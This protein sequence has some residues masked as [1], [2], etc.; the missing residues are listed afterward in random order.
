M[1]NS[2]VWIFT[3]D[4]TNDTRITFTPDDVRSELE[5]EFDHEDPDVGRELMY[6]GGNYE[7]HELLSDLYYEIFDVNEK[8]DGGIELTDEE[9][10]VYGGYTLNALS[11]FENALQFLLESVVI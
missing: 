10:L 3:H 11:A 7:L 5:L 1:D 6:F 8:I 4:H 9:D 2:T